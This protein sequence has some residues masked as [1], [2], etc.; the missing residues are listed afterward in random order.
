MSCISVSYLRQNEQQSLTLLVIAY[1]KIHKKETVL[2]I[3]QARE[4]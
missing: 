3:N 4:T 2:L 1:L